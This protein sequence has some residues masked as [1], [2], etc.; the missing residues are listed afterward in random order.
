MHTSVAPEH[1]FAS[2]QALLLERITIIYTTGRRDAQNGGSC[3]CNTR[4]Q[5]L[6]KLYWQLFAD[7]NVE[8]VGENHEDIDLQVLMHV[9]DLRKMYQG[10]NN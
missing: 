8:E 10:P 3:A 2:F 1:R 7:V 6:C 9:G 5:C 4:T